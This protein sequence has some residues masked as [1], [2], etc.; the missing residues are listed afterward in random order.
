MFTSNTNTE[1]VLDNY[2]FE[3]NECLT[4]Q[5][6]KDSDIINNEECHKTKNAILY[7]KNSS[8]NVLVQEETFDLLKDFEFEVGSVIIIIIFLNI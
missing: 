5:I 6:I 8:T 3:N 2:F 7:S 1:T 4:S